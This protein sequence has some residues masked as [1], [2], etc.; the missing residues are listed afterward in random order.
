MRT[1]HYSACILLA[2]LVLA[3]C[4]GGSAAGPNTCSLTNPGGCGGTAQP[5]PAPAPLP[6]PDPASKAA[7]ISLVFSN[8]ELGSAGLPDDEVKVTALVK[9]ADNTAVA[10]APITFAADSGFLAVGAVKTDSSGKASAVLGTGGSP[11]NRTIKVS[12]KVGAQSTSALVSVVGTRL[13]MA[14][15]SHLNLGESAELVAT[16]VDS[17]S[18]PISGETVTASVKNGN[19]LANASAVSDSRGQVRLKLQASQRGDEQVTVSALGASMAKPVRV[20]GSELMLLPSVTVGDSG[21][22]TLKEIPVGI[23]SPL[24]GRYMV[25]QAGSVTVTASRGALFSDAACT[26]PLAGMLAISGGNMTRTYIRSDNAGISTVDAVVSGGAAAST[27][28]E[29]V[30]PLAAS[31]KV[32]LQT[33]VAVIGSGERSGLIAVVRD[34]TPANNLVKG[35]LVQFSIVAD[36]SG[37]NLLSP[38]TAITGS[39]GV[40]RATFIAGPADGGKDGTLIQARLAALPA[41]TATTAVTVN[42][43][44]LSIQFGTGNTLFEYSPAVLQKD[45]SVFVSDSAGSPVKDVAISV[46]AWP[47]MYRKGIYDWRPHNPPLQEPGMWVLVHPITDC[48][49]EDVARRGLYDRAFDRNGNG[50]LEPGIPLSVVSSGKTD[51]FGMATVSLR[52]PRDRANWVRVELTV[53]G[54]VAGTES[55]ARNAFWLPALGK[56]LDRFGVSPPGAESPYGTYPSCNISL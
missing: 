7:S 1:L 38:Y 35:A 21:I 20:S 9:T 41:A 3:G 6:A 52:Y 10:D 32:N 16:L 37:G 51:S 36:P 19:Q 18:R 43:K 24:D 46:A 44:A 39:D 22:E 2:G 4:G 14:G 23:C 49:N 48:D 25:S 54:T 31:S 40:A 56:D 27:R 47:T 28:L 26:R 50:V 15:P 17:A 11:L 30:A 53:S 33:D 12:A 34:G 5:V 13:S 45:F 42:K 55:R 8:S 29:F